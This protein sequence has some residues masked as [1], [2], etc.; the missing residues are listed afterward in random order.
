M[1][2]ADTLRFIHDAR[3]KGIL[4]RDRDG[5]VFTVGAL[6]DLLAYR[7]SLTTYARRQDGTIGRRRARPFFTQSHHR[8]EK[9]IR[10]AAEWLRRAYPEATR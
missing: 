2:D 1:S 7:I 10:E 6:G 4:V 3:E 5:I 9:A 8:P